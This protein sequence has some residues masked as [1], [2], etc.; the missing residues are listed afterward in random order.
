M[1]HLCDIKSFKI[2][3]IFFFSS[4]SSHRNTNQYICDVSI[5]FW[6]NIDF[7]SLFDNLRINLCIYIFI[8]FWCN[9]N[10]IRFQPL[11]NINWFVQNND[12]KQMSALFLIIVDRCVYFIIFLFFSCLKFVLSSAQSK[13]RTHLIHL[14]RM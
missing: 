6:Y 8:I 3:I 1:P 4:S 14:D 10:T 12:R 5:S 13:Q 7:D 11:W 9:N 2:G